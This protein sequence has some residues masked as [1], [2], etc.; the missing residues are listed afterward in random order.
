M[1]RGMDLYKVHPLVTRF[2]QSIMSKQMTNRAVVHRQGV[3]E[4]G[5][6][7]IKR[8][9]L[10]IN[11]QFLVLLTMS[12]NPFIREFQKMWHGYQHFWQTKINYLFYVNDLKVYGTNDNQMNG[13]INMGN[14]IW[15]HQDWV[16]SRQVCQ[17][18]IQ[19]RKKRLTVRIQL[20]DKSFICELELEGTYSSLGIEEGNLICSQTHRRRWLNWVP[21]DDDQKLEGV[22]KRTKLIFEPKLKEEKHKHIG[23]PRCCIQLWRT[24]KCMRSK[25]LNRWPGNNSE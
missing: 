3:L 12:L 19:E 17:I 15:L 24:R 2:V 11:L 6:I 9:I 10:L 4:T 20:I 25:V 23:S 1:I 5:L 14:G 18:Y 7:S 8:G 16:Q 21:Q 13:L 22:Q